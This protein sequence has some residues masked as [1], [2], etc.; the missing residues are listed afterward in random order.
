MKSH[1]LL[2]STLALLGSLRSIA[3][4][5]EKTGV[6]T[7]GPDLYRAIEQQ[8]SRLFQAYNTCDL[9]TFRS[10]LADD[11][12][13]YHDVTGLSTGADTIT[14]QIKEN[15][16]GKTVRELVPGSLEVHPLHGYG[17]VE[18]GSHQFHAP[19]QQVK[20]AAR[21]VQLWRYDNGT[22]RLSRVISYNHEATRGH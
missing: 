8:D 22:W 7:D 20:G 18:I 16:C 15:V 14:E 4:A 2:Y 11:I 9:K 17:A 21:F 5:Q 19:G 1:L 12:E 13:F 6:P 3:L 10:M